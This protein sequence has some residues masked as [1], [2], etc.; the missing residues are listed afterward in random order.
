M[1][2]KDSISKVVECDQAGEGLKV[3]ECYHVY[4]GK[5]GKG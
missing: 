3:L 5:W 4:E 1:L 2:M